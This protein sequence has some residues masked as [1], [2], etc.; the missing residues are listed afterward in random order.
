MLTSAP[1]ARAIAAATLGFLLVSGS[2]ARVGH[3]VML[4][5]TQIHDV[6]GRSSSAGEALVTVALGIGICLLATSA[7]R[8]LEDGW[9]RWLAQ[10]GQVLAVVGI[11]IALVAVLAAV[12]GRLTYPS[13]G[14]I[15]G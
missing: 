10:S 7:A 4:V 1:Q 3:N 6:T 5:F 14:P 2:L 11:V 8:Q 13:F 15:V 12:A 9:A